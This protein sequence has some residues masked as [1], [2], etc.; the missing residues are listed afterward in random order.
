MAHPH[1]Q[2]KDH[3]VQ[4]RRVGHI[5]KGYAAGGAVHDDEKADKALIKRSVKK[6]AM[7]MDG[8]RVKQRADRRARGGAVYPKE[9]SEAQAQ[10]RKKLA[11]ANKPTMRASGGRTKKH[12]GTTVNI[13][14][15]PGHAAG[16]PPMPP[17]GMMP[18]RPPVA[19]GPPTGM[20]PAAAPPAAPPPMSP[21]V[22]PMAPPMG[23]PGP[24]PPRRGGGRTYA[25]GG[26]VKSGPAWEEGVHAGTKPHNS[27]G[28]KDGKDIGRGRQITYAKGGAVGPRLVQFYAGGA[29]KRATGGKVESPQGVA[30]ATKLPGG[31]G[32]GEARLTK[33]HRAAKGYKKA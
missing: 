9:G 24:M 7:R 4:H 10:V 30:P 27:P 13:I 6:S 32:G 20:P 23:M 1:E 2:H 33:A 26:A 8:G 18:P 11:F 3:K 5:T 16:G 22:R 17:P 14:N 12:K 15:S 29:V 21:A 31:G 25:K 19:P 28:K